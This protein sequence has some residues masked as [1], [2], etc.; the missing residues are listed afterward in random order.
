[1]HFQCLW[2]VAGLGPSKQGCKNG[3]KNQRRVAT[4]LLSKWPSDQLAPITLPTWTCNNPNDTQLRQPEECP[5][6][7]A[8]GGIASHQILVLSWEAPEGGNQH[9]P[10][11][12]VTEPQVRGIEG[13]RGENHCRFCFWWLIIHLTKKRGRGNAGGY[14]ERGI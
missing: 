4:H 1:M 9:L 3:S 6:P 11:V 8:A 5:C 10:K 12:E 14:G 7:S 13:Q 2:D